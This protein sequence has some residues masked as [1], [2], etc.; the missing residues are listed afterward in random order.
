MFSSKC[1]VKA[2]K[3]RKYEIY[4]FRYDVSAYCK[5][6]ASI[7]NVFHTNGKFHSP[8]FPVAVDL[9]FHCL[10][11]KFRRMKRFQAKIFFTGF[12]I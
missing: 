4:R 2:K 3:S 9:P 1:M 11:F 7:T 12:F 6:R 8:R 5:I 10:N